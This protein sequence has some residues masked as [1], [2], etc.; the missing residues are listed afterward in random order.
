[1]EVGEEIKEEEEDDTIET[2]YNNVQKKPKNQK[3]KE[4]STNKNLEKKKSKYSINSFRK[5]FDSNKKK[6]QQN[7]SDYNFKSFSD[8]NE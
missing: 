8:D 7:N 1:M 2:S 6:K 5:G 4:K 3:T